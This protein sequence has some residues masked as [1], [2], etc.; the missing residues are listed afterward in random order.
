MEAAGRVI[1]KPPR[2]GNSSENG[3]RAGGLS[4]SR[5]SLVDGPNE[6]PDRTSRTSQNGTA[7]LRIIPVCRN[8]FGYL[9]PVIAAISYG[10]VDLL[11]QCFANGAHKSNLRAIAL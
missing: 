10:S 9:S 1:L 2:S 11:P 7:V 6:Y 4:C 5:G 8:K 3:A